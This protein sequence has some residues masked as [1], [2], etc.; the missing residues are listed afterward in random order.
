MEDLIKYKKC[1]ATAR[2][3][4][5]LKKI[6][7]WQEFSETINLHTDIK[8]TWNQAKIFKNK[9]VKTNYTNIKKNLQNQELINKS[10]EKICPPWANTNTEYVPLCDT[11]DFFDQPFDYSEFNIALIK[12]NTKSSSGMDGINYEII[13]NSPINHHLLLLDIF[14]EMFKTNQ[15]PDE[16]KNSFIHFVEKPNGNGMRPLALSSCLAK[17]F[18]TLIINR[19]NY[20]LETNNYL[21]NNQTGFR[22]GR[23][24]MDNL[25]TLLLNIKESFFKKQS[26]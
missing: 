3:V 9:W 16:W 25:T 20:W 11:N 8:Y 17:L 24:C 5:K 22:K 14:N 2:K 18:D 12:K 15:Y 1:I 4:F 7:K 21:P 23:S 13:K 10:L 19:L 26:T 6:S